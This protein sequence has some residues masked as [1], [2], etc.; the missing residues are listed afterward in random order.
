MVAAHAEIT[1]LRAAHVRL[2]SAVSAVYFAAVWSPDRPCDDQ[3]IW[4]ELRDAACIEPGMSTAALVKPEGFYRDKCKR[5]RFDGPTPC[6][7]CPG[8][9]TGALLQPKGIS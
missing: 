7:C 8:E 3:K 2:L 1:R 6:L 9:C 4:T 5:L